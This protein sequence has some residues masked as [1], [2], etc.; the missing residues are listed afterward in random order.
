MAKKNYE[1]K[2]DTVYVDVE[3][4]TVKEREVIQN[5]IA[6]GYS[7]KVK[8]QASDKV[9]LTKKDI[10]KALADNPIALAHFKEV[11]ET[12]GKNGKGTLFL[13]AKGMYLKEELNG[14]KNAK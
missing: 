2:K 11:A 7:V 5:Y 14:M 9:T 10:E 1:V 3:K 8:K 12:K 6:I 13:K 4:L